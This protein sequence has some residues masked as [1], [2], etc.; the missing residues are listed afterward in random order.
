MYSFRALAEITYCRCR[1]V[2][3]NGNAFAAFPDLASRI[4]KLFPDNRV[5]L[6]DEIV[7]LDK[8]VRPQFKNLLFHPGEPA[9]MV[10]DLLFDTSTDLRR[11]Q[12]TDR[13]QRCGLCSVTSLK[14]NC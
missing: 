8:R 14:M 7:C 1:L 5:V 13:K 2:S 10:F 9:F 11:E 3:R 6:D 12:V 4:G